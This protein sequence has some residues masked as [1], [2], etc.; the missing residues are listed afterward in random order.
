MWVHPYSYPLFLFDRND[1]MTLMTAL[2]P[3]KT[4]KAHKIWILYHSQ[5]PKSLLYPSPIRTHSKSP[6]HPPSA[7]HPFNNARP[8]HHHPP[9]IATP[10]TSTATSTQRPLLP[11]LKP[12]RPSPLKL[13]DSL[14]P[15]NSTLSILK[16]FKNYFLMSFLDVINCMSIGYSPFLT[17]S[18]YGLDTALVPKS[19]S[20]NFLKISHSSPPHPPPLLLFFFI[21]VVVWKIICR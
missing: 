16:I 7:P 14:P 4:H 21:I 12:R 5:H 19:K 10:T 1:R 18:W 9:P 8:C 17:P 20:L 13:L 6:L 11:P 3:Y 15:H 2:T